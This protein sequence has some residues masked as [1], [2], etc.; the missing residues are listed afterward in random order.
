MHISHEL[1][2]RGYRQIEDIGWGEGF[3]KERNEKFRWL[4]SKYIDRHRF[5]IVAFR[6]ERRLF[7]PRRPR[8]ILG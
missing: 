4:A 7:F 3:R 2:A 5:E 8:V 1:K 6:G